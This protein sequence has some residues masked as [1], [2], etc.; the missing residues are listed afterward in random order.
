MKE[1]DY[2][3]LRGKIKEV[4]GTN[5]AFAKKLGCSLNTLSQKLNNKYEF[6]QGDILRSTQILKIPVNDIAD[7]FFCTISLDS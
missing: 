1:F 7:Y 2:S 3:K 6:T 4:C 5:T